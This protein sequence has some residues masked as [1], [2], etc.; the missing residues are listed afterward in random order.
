MHTFQRQGRGL[1][2]RLRPAAGADMQFSS[3][4]V[5]LQASRTGPRGMGGVWGV[6]AGWVGQVARV[7]GVG[8][9]WGGRRTGGSGTCLMRGWWASEV[10][11]ASGGCA[12][13]GA[14]VCKDG[15]IIGIRYWQYVLGWVIY[16]CAVRGGLW[17]RGRLYLSCDGC[18]CCVARPCWPCAV[19][20]VRVRGAWSAVVLRRVC[21]CVAL[22][23]D[24]HVRRMPL[25]PCV[26]RA[27]DKPNIR[28]RKGSLWVLSPAPLTIKRV[29]FLSFYFNIE[30]V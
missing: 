21:A 14:A 7:R 10:G 9:A 1:L 5:V 18:A 22:A 28:K 4:L 29:L 23:A 20:G 16:V 12:G 3:P 15:W 27:W 17:T 30:G 26:S 6:E 25:P 19:C 2:V 8:C 11:Q 24:Y 13:L